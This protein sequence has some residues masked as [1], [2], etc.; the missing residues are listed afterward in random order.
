M[1]AASILPKEAMF[2]GD[3]IENDIVGANGVGITSVL[4]DPKSR[5]DNQIYPISNLYAVLSCLEN[6]QG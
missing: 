1:R 6:K 3:T 5:T 2:V 4:I